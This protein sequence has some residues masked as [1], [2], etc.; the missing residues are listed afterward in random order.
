MVGDY[1]HTRQWAHQLTQNLLVSPG[2]A[3]GAVGAILHSANT[4]HLP[5]RVDVSAIAVLALQEVRVSL[6]RWNL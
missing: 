5:G 4:S 3:D 6:P 1:V 2:M